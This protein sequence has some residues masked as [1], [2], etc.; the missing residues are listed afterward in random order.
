MLARVVLGKTAACV[1]LTEGHKGRHRGGS[2]AALPSAEIP[3]IISDFGTVVLA[4][5]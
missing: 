1:G 4:F 2:L 3:Q 5:L